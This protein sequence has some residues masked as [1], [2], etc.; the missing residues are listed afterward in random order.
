MA[1]NQNLQKYLTYLD[2]KIICFTRGIELGSE[3]LASE[4][5]Y[6]VLSEIKRARDKFYEL[7]PELKPTEPA[8]T[9][10]SQLAQLPSQTEAEVL[11]QRTEYLHPDGGGP[12]VRGRW[13]EMDG[14]GRTF[15]PDTP[16]DNIDPLP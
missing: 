16:L 12:A 4:F 8:R 14:G 6:L 7:F 2:N 10:E 1:E 3:D 15:M 5:D 9:P 13:V 11:S